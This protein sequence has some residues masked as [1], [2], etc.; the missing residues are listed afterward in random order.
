MSRSN[1]SLRLLSVGSLP[2]EW[3]GTH[4][5]G[6]ATFHATLLAELASS[7][8]PVECVGV[9]VAPSDEIDRRRAERRAGAPVR[10]LTSHR[11]RKGDYRR[12]LRRARP[13]GVLF[14]HVVN[15]SVR[16]LVN[17]HRRIAPGIPSVGVAH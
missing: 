12:A 10:T 4:R 14:N 8:H 2:P 5:G 9:L 6:V 7:R 11:A 1:R 17:V 16:P 15:R 3:G 13:D